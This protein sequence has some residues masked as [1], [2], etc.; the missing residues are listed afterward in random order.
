MAYLIDNVSKFKNKDVEQVVLANNLND[1]FKVVDPYEQNLKSLVESTISNISDNLYYYNGNLQKI[2][3]DKIQEKLNLNKKELDSLNEAIESNDVKEFLKSFKEII[4]TKAKD[5]NIKIY[6]LVGKYTETINNLTTKR[7]INPEYMSQMV[8]SVTKLENRRVNVN[9]Q[10]YFVSKVMEYKEIV[11]SDKNDVF[12]Y[13]NLK[14]IKDAFDTLEQNKDLNLT[15]E[16]HVKNFYNTIKQLKTKNT[17][18]NH[19]EIF[20]ND[21]FSVKDTLMNNDIYRFEKINEVKKNLK[22][23]IKD[24][25]MDTIKE[26]LKVFYLKNED[27][28]NYVSNDKRLEK[29]KEN[30]IIKNFTIEDYKEIGLDNKDI[31][32]IITLNQVINFNDLVKDFSGSELNVNATYLFY[33]KFD[34]EMNDK[35]AKKHVDSLFKKFQ[36][37]KDSSVSNK[38]NILIL[39]AL[40][41]FNKETKKYSKKMETEYLDLLKKPLSSYDAK[42]IE[43]LNTIEDQWLKWS[44]C[45]DREIQDRNLILTN[46]KPENF[47]FVNYQKTKKELN[48]QDMTPEK[49]EIIQLKTIFKSLNLK[50]VGIDNLVPTTLAEKELLKEFL[51]LKE[52]KIN[53]DGI[54][55]D[56]SDRKKLYNALEV[57][58]NINDNDLGEKLIETNIVKYLFELEESKLKVVLDNFDKFKNLDI[59]AGKMVNFLKTNKKSVGNVLKSLENFNKEEIKA[60]S[61]ML[62]N[63][64]VIPSTVEN[65]LSLYIKYY[66][67]KMNTPKYNEYKKENSVLPMIEH[68][69]NSKYTLRPLTIKEFASV[70][71]GEIGHHCMRYNCAS[72]GM[73]NF[74]FNNPEKMYISQLEREGE[75]I[76]NA[77]TWVKQ[78]T[79]CFD[80]IEVLTHENTYLDIV[81]NGYRELTMKYLLEG[82]E[83]GLDRVTMGKSNH[84]NQGFNYSKLSIDVKA[85]SEHPFVYISRN[86]ISY[87]DADSQQSLIFS[88]NKK[89]LTSVKVTNFMIDSLIIYSEFK[90]CKPELLKEFITVFKEKTNEIAEVNSYYKD[91]IKINKLEEIERKIIS[92]NFKN[93][94]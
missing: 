67:T 4:Y 25:D 41:S 19:N 74:M 79:I 69:V 63:I 70:I 20:I 16:E 28:I 58:K 71:N 85:H 11:D 54:S 91:N 33:E 8:E 18:I 30:A 80:S 81:S 21:G 62:D 38:N 34:V 75:G 14:T 77:A 87:S 12:H 31:E 59:E 48:I 32:K 26:A 36:E 35:N 60:L 17:K 51:Q 73:I 93:I 44:I 49:V 94:D 72:W 24:Y 86:E 65:D 23:R 89:D 6:D 78:N 76:A 15:N 47:D 53:L 92:N 37:L 83:K 27:L 90:D 10:D 56:L 29:I 43:K 68:K 66:A 64:K 46:I 9:I 84:N 13:Y 42:D 82:A 7:F 57:Y 3:V 39:I 55:L 88:L 2:E 1:L 5:K 40:S 61:V 50:K 22:S 52:H 45:Y